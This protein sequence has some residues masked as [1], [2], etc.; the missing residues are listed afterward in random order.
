[1]CLSQLVDSWTI[2]CNVYQIHLYAIVCLAI[3]M[4]GVF[5]L[6]EKQ[7]IF[8]VMAVDGYAL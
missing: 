7:C 6:S 2:E 1:M 8:C 3:R 4:T 5:N